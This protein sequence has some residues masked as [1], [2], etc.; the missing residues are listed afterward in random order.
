[1]HYLIP[2]SNLHLTVNNKFRNWHY[3]WMSQ[4]TSCKFSWYQES[5]ICNVT[6]CVF[7]FADCAFLTEFAFVWH[8]ITNNRI[9]KSCWWTRSCSWRISD[10][11][12]N[13][14]WLITLMYFFLIDWRF[15]SCKFISMINEF[16][17]IS[18]NYKW[19]NNLQNTNGLGQ[20]IDNC[21]VF[22]YL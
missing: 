19:D 4:L 15:Y 5:S 14:I 20:T 16:E 6:D 8:V 11:S 12:L 7:L 13:L 3:V 21:I 9:R 17:E 22:C 10:V 18:C 1:M 2:L